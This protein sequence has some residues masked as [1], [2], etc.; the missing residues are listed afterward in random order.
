MEV[1]ITIGSLI[2]SIGMM[3]VV[4]SN[5]WDIWNDEKDRWK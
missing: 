4:K 5:G 3:Y 1:I 2:I